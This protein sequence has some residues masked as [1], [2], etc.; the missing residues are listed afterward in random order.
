MRLIEMISIFGIG[1]DAYLIVLCI[2]LPLFFIWRR[3][4]KKIKNQNKRIVVTWLIT[5]LSAPIAYILIFAAIFD[6][7]MYYPNRNF[8]KVKWM[9]DKDT[10]YEYADNI[11]S[12]KMLVGQSPAEVEKLLGTD[13]FSEQDGAWFYDLGFTPGSI[14]PDSMEIDFKGGKVID[15]IRHKHH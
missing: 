5:L 4:L 12:S 6:I 14:D 2:S 3:L 13:H 11:I 9:N 1:A 15:V 10:R 7:Q 8:D